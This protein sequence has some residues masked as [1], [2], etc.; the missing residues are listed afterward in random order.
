MERWLCGLC[1]LCLLWSARAEPGRP[2]VPVTLAESGA[3]EGAFMGV[4]LLGTLR[5]PVEPAAGVR[6]GGVSGLAWDE[7]EQMLYALSDVGELYHLQP[8]FA[9]E[10][11]VDVRLRGVYPLRD[12]A[13]QP[14]KF[15]WNDAEGLALANGA[16]GLPGDSELIIA[17]EARPRLERY[18]SDGQPLGAVPL[19]AP[20]NDVRHYNNPNKSLESVVLH[21]HYGPL[22]APEWSMVGDAPGSVTLAALQGP[23]WRYRLSSAPNSGLV[24]LALLPDGSLLALERGFVALTRPLIITLRRVTLP[25]D[26]ALPLTVRDVAVFNSAEGWLLDNFEGLTHHRDGRFFMI[27]DDN[28]SILQNT[29]LVYFRLREPGF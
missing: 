4:E 23:R 10:R 29:L 3:P 1:L 14:L 16:N 17:F 22:V 7:D 20:F 21:P 25:A 13:G 12:A 6:L 27:S 5:L 11:L 9:A 19:P 28:R 15:T 18:R 24:D 8:V 2:A 26:P